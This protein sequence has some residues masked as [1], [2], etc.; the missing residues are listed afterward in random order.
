VNTIPLTTKVKF[1]SIPPLTVS[2]K[3]TSRNRLRAIDVEEAAKN[4]REEARNSFESYLY[5]LRDLLSDDNKETPFIKCSQD[6]ERREIS[7][8]L[9]E[10]F[11]WLFDRGDLAETS[12]FLNKRIALETMEKPIIHRYQEIEAF[13]QVL[14]NSQMWNWSTRMFLQEARQNLTAETAASLPSKW[15]KEELDGLEKTLREHESWLS[16]WVEKQKSVKANQDPVIETTEMKARAKV[17]ETHLHKLWK[18]KVPKAPRKPVST[19][20][21]TTTTTSTL[22]PKATPGV[23]DDNETLE[24]SL[25]GDIEGSEE[26]GEQIP[27]MEEENRPPKYV[28]EEL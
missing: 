25:E 18:R 14:N 13:P 8:K 26:D 12:Q 27:M 11:Q 17:L 6:G 3:K 16:E 22:V 23:D 2:E 5:R 19:S 1:T 15:T 28:H 24:E 4:R 10:S 9:D 21:S 20:S 7:E